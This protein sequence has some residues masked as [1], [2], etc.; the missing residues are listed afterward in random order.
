MCLIYIPKGKTV[1]EIEFR[2]TLS[3]K[4]NYNFSR[5]DE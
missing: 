4:R 1:L 5:L 2:V 3:N